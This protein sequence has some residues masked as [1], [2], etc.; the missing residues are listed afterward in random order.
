MPI[1]PRDPCRKALSNPGRRVRQSTETATLVHYLTFGQAPA[2]DQYGRPLFAYGHLIHDQCERRANFD[3]GRVVEQWGD[4]GHRNGWCLYEMGC[5]GPSTRYNC[6]IV[7]WNDETNWPIG[8]GHGCIGCAAPRSWD[9]MSPFYGR[10]PDV[11]LLGVDTQAQTIGL[12]AIGAVAAATAVHATGVVISRRR[13][14]RRAAA[15][16]GPASPPPDAAQPTTPG[17][18]S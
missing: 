17:A 11:K 9:T 15:E 18:A 7:R 1:G 5:K 8:A 3:A 10:L 4:E 13:A 2:L 12:A 16:R 14:A 6:P